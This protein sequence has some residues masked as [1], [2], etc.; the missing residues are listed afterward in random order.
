VATLA[1]LRVRV[2]AIRAG[3][4]RQPERGSRSSGS[5]KYRQQAV[6]AATSG[7]GSQHP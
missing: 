2:V 1:E 3:A 5:K 4:V 7:S 6:A